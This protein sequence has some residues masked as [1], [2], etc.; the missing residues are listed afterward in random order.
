[1][2]G[3]ADDLLRGAGLCRQGPLRLH[4]ATDL[5]ATHTL[6]T[7]QG[8][9]WL[10]VSDTGQEA[11]LT[12]HLAAQHPTLVPPLLGADPQRGAL[13]TG[14][15]GTLLDGVGDLGAWT[16]A[17]ERLA[18]FQCATDAAALAAHGAPALPLAQMTERVDA[19]L[20]DL[21][22]LR[23]WGLSAQE[24]TTLQAA[25]AQ[26][27]AAFLDLHQHGLPDLPAHGDAHPRNVLHSAAR[28]P[29]W[30]D[31]SEAASAAHPFMD[32][33][34][35]LAFALHPSR[36]GLPVW[37]AHDA[38]DRMAGTYLHAL[39]APDAAPLLH[40]A[41][42]LALLHR[43]AV[44]DVAFRNWQGTVPGVRPNYVPY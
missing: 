43:A 27:R 41:L 37:Q 34:W 29:V 12:R 36:A 25:R 20:G 26:I 19:L 17:L 23:G 14:D 24:V 30:F 21:A 38:A 13:L 8:P 15:G 16:G 40:R 42:P 22:A 44:Y 3:L 31:W 9:A 6:H 32:A 7:S 39:G 33:G 11:R 2:T 28:G 1:M 10:K 5:T 4:F 18:R 35:F